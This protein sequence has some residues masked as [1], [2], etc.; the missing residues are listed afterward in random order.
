[1]RVPRER[2]KK[3]KKGRIRGKCLT[4]SLGMEGNRRRQLSVSSIE[5]LRAN[6]IPRSGYIDSEF[7]MVFLIALLKGNGASLEIGWVHTEGK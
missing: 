5:G 6:R 7:Q 4:Q 2:E 3:K 1:M